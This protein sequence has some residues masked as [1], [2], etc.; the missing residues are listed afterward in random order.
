M[1]LFASFL[2]F[3]IS[4]S[5]L[6]QELSYPELQVTPRASERIYLEAKAENESELTS[7]LSIQLMAAS[8]AF[9]GLQ[10]SNADLVDGLS[11]DDKSIEES[12]QQLYSI[13]SIGVGAAWLGASFYA[14]KFYKPYT[15][16]IKKVNKLKGKSKRAR[17]TKERMAEEE[18][19]TMARVGTSVRWISALSGLVSNGLLLSLKTKSG[20]DDPKVYASIGAA[21]SLT[22]LF[23]K[24]KWERVAEQQDTYK[25]KIYGP[26]A[27]APILIDPQTGSRATGMN[28]LFRF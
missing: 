26:V 18:I 2:I 6:A 23:F 1:N 27:Y 9:A 12:K 8:S 5:V 19:R 11:S 20:D 17:L 25:K 13:I 4:S 14:M 15:S 3:S 24:T 28:L 16:A 7:L 21:L 10:Y 22:P